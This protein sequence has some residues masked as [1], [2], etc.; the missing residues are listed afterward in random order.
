M[1]ESVLHTNGQRLVGEVSAT[2]SHPAGKDFASASGTFT[3][4]EA[5]FTF[6]FALRGLIFCTKLLVANLLEDG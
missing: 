3:D 5:V 1:K 4:E 2:S 6:T